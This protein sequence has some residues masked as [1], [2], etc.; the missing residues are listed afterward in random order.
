MK[1]VTGSPKETEHFGEMLGEE[2][3]K[4]RLRLSS[5]L[6]VALYGNLGAGKTVFVKGFAKGVGAKG[7]ISSPTFLI[8]RRLALK[9]NQAGFK[10][11]FHVDA[12]RIRRKSELGH[13]DF[14]KIVAN[15]KN[16]VV[17]EW[18]SKTLTFLKKSLVKVA[19]WH[20]KS[21]KER[22]IDFSLVA[23]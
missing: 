1:I 17:I 15:P 14:Q 23:R 12:Y 2:I 22:G 16:I 5:A 21:D 9:K 3:L 19:M 6:I 8:V 13:I 20:G 4:K 18:A 7:K 11:L 10:N